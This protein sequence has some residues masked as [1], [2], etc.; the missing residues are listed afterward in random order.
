MEECVFISSGHDPPPPKGM[1]L[2]SWSFCIYSTVAPLR[3]PLK[4][5]VTLLRGMGFHGRHPWGSVGMFKMLNS[6]E[7]SPGFTSKNI[8]DA[9]GGTLPPGLSTLD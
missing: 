6:L 8:P 7:N 2:A 4:P 3:S 5:S 9:A 1:P